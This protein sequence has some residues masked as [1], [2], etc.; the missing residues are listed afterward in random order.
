MSPAHT[1]RAYDEELRSLNARIAEM[2]RLA[3]A[4]LAGA[5]SALL[6]QNADLAARVIAD[7]ARLD[8]LE[9]QAEAAAID[10]IARRQ[11]LAIDLREIMASVRIAGI[12][13]R[14]GDHAKNT[15][16][17]ATAIMREGRPYELPAGIGALASLATTQL[18]AV[19]EAYANRDVEQAAAVWRSDSEIDRLYTALFRELLTYMMEDSRSITP[20][21]HILFCAKNIERIGDHATNIA[22]IV[23]FLVTGSPPMSERPKGDDTSSTAQ[24]AG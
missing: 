14:V 1:V 7:D 8:E 4:Q 23:E 11:P 13:E 18:A 16:K 15:A 12:L 19:L 24:V 6:N 5:V 22:E 9:K 17:R 3:E 20:A 2:G 21:T 10:V